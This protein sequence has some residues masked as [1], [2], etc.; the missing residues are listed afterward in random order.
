MLRY[1]RLSI[2]VFIGKEGPEWPA[3]NGTSRRHDRLRRTRGE[4]PRADSALAERNPLGRPVGHEDLADDVPGRNRA[5]DTRV[6][7]LRAIVA[8]DEV[9]AERYA[10]RLGGTDVA[11]VLLD[12][13]LVEPLPVDVDV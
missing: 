5:P 12:V 3:G 6:A 13:R 1:S 8:H 4:S 10:V 11:A 7:R 2:V 9:V